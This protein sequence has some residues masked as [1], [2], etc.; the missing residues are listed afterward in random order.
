[1]AKI[2]ALLRAHRLQNADLPLPL[3]GGGHHG[4]DDAESRG[5]H[6]HRG[7]ELQGDVDRA[8]DGEDRFEHLLVRDHAQAD[9]F[10]DLLDVAI[11]AGD[12]VHLDRHVGDPIAGLEEPLGKGQGKEQGQVV[13]AAGLLQDP[14]DRQLFSADGDLA[15][16][17]S[18]N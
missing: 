6:R 5:K 13:P 8:D 17:F 2:V 12:V 14:L 3:V 1:M 11:G 4:V 16:G 15:P 7:N 9:R 18:P 10:L